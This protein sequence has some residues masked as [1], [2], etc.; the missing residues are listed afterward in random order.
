[1]NDE[2][3]KALKQGDKVY[4]KKDGFNNSIY[5]LHTVKKIT[6]K[7][8]VRLDDD[9][10]YLDGYRRI[11]D[12]Y[13]KLKLV[14]W[15]PELEIELEEKAHLRIMQNMINNLDMRTQPTE[16]VQAIYDQIWPGKTE[17]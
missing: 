13:H 16:V 2:W 8:Y 17:E 12:S 11:I 3:I 5:V 10:L 15:T 14:Q 1:M 4:T 6:P 9:S 7:G